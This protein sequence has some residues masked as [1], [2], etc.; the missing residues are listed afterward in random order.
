MAASIPEA[1]RRDAERRGRLAEWGAALALRLKGYR[2]LA[3]R[4]RAS[5]GEADLVAAR[6]GG[7]VFVEVKARATRA[8]ALAAVTP[9]QCRRVEQAAR[10]FVAANPTWVDRPIRFDV[11]AMLP[12][13]WPVHVRDAW[14]PPAPHV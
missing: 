2:I 11:I 6:A 9:R 8:A 3:R 5:G 4:F 14:R 10:A 13:R 12:G 1:G 7:L